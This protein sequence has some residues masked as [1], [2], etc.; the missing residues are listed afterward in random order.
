MVPTCT[1]LVVPQAMNIPVTF[2]DLISELVS[3]RQCIFVWVEI[4]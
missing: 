1:L 2:I 4:R 3:G